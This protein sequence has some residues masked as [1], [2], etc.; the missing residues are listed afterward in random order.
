MS[1][2]DQQTPLLPRQ[3]PLSR[4]FCQFHGFGLGFHRTSRIPANDLTK[5]VSPSFYGYSDIALEHATR[6]RQHACL[7]RL[8]TFARLESHLRVSVNLRD[9]LNA[10]RGY[11]WD[12]N[13]W[14]WLVEF[15][16]VES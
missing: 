11:G 4:G 12:V 3:F 15:R 10:A 8:V 5:G 13:P 6:G 14:V 1:T 9:G 7:D 2:N 16:R